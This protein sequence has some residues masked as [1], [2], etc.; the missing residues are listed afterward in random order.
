MK[1]A[2]TL[3]KQFELRNFN[4]SITRADYEANFRVTNETVEFSFG[5]WDGKSYDGETRKAR[6]VRCL[7]PGFEEFRYVKVGKGVQLI[8]DD[9]EVLEKATGL[10]HNGCCWMFDVERA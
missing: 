5:G 7:I 1:N 2:F 4:T 8:E 9:Y 10:Y 6:V 3:R